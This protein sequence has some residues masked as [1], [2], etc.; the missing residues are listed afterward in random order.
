M[1]SSDI[2]SYERSLLLS[3]VLREPIMKSII[4]SMRLPVSGFGLD[5]GCGIGFTTFMLAEAVAP[6]G[7]VIGFDA[8]EGFLAKAR[9]LLKNKAFIKDRVAF[10]YG[11]SGKLPFNDN[12]FDWACSMD[13][14]GAIPVD[15][16]ILLKETVG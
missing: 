11:D 15:P 10:A 13:C 4:N 5:I 1:N 8:E 6:E 7:N 9:L 12:S 3:Q 14:V 16:L 2:S